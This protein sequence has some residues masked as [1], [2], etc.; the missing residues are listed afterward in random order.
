MLRATSILRAA[1]ASAS[2][3]VARGS[4]GAAAPLR[5]KLSTEITGLDVHPTPLS[6]LKDT[7]TSTL[8]LLS[9]LPPN[10]VYAQA[11][12]ALTE[13]RL[14]V[15]QSVQSGG[16]TEEAIAAFEEQVDAGQAEEVLVQAQDELALTTKMIEWQ[17]HEP[18]KNPP[19]AGQ[20]E[21]TSISQE[22][23]EGGHHT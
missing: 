18:L 13:H 21:Y 20:W 3:A 7:Y 14:K 12:K 6:A 11:T 17:A 1:S 4:A 23:G 16:A 5:T 15:L 2:S 19:P 8:N 9:T 22:I 10:S